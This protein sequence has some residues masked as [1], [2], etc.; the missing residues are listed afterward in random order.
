MCITPQDEESFPCQALYHKD[1]EIG[2][3]FLM[4]E[5]PLTQT[6]MFKVREQF[7]A[8]GRNSIWADTSTLQLFGE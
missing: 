6:E 8:S 1:E 5:R 2:S 4:F 3:T 7:T